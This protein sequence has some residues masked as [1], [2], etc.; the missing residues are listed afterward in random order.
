MVKVYTR[1]GDDG[2]THS[3][4]S[5][6]MSKDDIQ[7]DAIGTVDE[8][9]S[10]IGLLLSFLEAEE[11]SVLDESELRQLQSVQNHLFDIGGALATYS[12]AEQFSELVGRIEEQPLEA[13]ID[14]MDETLPAIRQFILPGGSTCATQAHVCRSVCRRA[15]RLVV[16]VFKSLQDESD[17][18][19]SGIAKLMRYL[20]RLSDLLFVLARYLNQKSNHKEVFWTGKE[21]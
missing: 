18:V 8:L 17:S 10:Q 9:N 4:G 6:R 7:L 14:S 5:G 19:T 21:N 20:N 1:T 16:A 13:W 2:T 3:F 11:Q 15:E 12:M